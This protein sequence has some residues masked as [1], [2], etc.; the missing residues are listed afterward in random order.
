MFR[1]TIF[2]ITTVL[3][4]KL[5]VSCIF[6]CDCDDPEEIEFALNTSHISLIDNAGYYPDYHTTSDTVSSRAIGFDITLSDSII[7][8]Q[9]FTALPTKCEQTAP[10][11]IKG[12]YAWSCDCVFWEFKAKQKIKA[13]RMIALTD[14]NQDLPAQSDISHLLVG[15]VDQSGFE[16]HGM[17]KTLEKTIE[18]LSEE[19]IYSSPE[20][21]FELYLTEAPVTDS[22]RF[23]LTF[24][25]DDNSFITDTTQM[26]YPLP[27]FEL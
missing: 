4:L 7:T 1:K 16:A 26:I 15:R 12:A 11:F 9:Y 13:I 24:E 21:S 5:L 19:R 20:Y 10:I 23:E 6:R 18:Y 17:Y 2:I 14:F 25:F 22:I 3:A 8:G 27:M